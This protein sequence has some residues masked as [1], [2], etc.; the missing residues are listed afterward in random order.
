MTIQQMLLGAGGKTDPK[1]IDDYWSTSH[2]EGNGQSSRTINNGIDFSSGKGMVFIV[3]STGEH[4]PYIFSTE[5]KNDNGSSKG[6]KATFSSGYSNYN[7]YCTLTSTGMTV[8]NNNV[9]NQNGSR[10]LAHFFKAEKGFFDIVT[11]TGNETQRTISHGLGTN[12][13]QM[14]IKRT[15]GSHAW[16]VYHKDAVTGNGHWM[17]LSNSNALQNSGNNDWYLSGFTSSTFG[18]GNHSSING[19]NKEYIAF[20]WSDGSDASWGEDKDEA[21]I[22]C[23]TYTGNGSSNRDSPLTVNVGFEPSFCLYKAP[24]AGGD[25]MMQNTINRWGG[26]DDG[27]EDRFNRINKYSNTNQGAIGSRHY[28]WIYNSGIKVFSNLNQNNQKYVYMAIRRMG[29][30]PITTAAEAYASVTASSATRNNN[31]LG[32]FAVPTG[33][34]DRNRTV[35]LMFEKRH[36]SSNDWE[37]GSRLIHGRRMPTNKDD[38]WGT[39]TGFDFSSNF[40]FGTGY[41]QYH[42]GNMF[43]RAYGY[44]DIQAYNG[45]NTNQ[46]ITHELGVVP[47]MIWFKNNAGTNMLCAI[48]ML[49]NNYWGATL[50]IGARDGSD[51]LNKSRYDKQSHGWLSADPTAT[52]VYLRG[53][54]NANQFKWTNAPWNNGQQMYLWK[55][56]DGVMKIGTYNGNNSSWGNAINCGFSNGCAFILVKRYNGNGGGEVD[57]WIC[58]TEQGFNTNNSDMMRLNRENSMDGSSRIINNY[59][60]GFRVKGDLN[61][62]DSKWFYM[63]VAAP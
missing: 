5:A 41:N 11:Y 14:W 19:N 62:S 23:G 61:Y 55:Q 35:D 58:N 47:D 17:N 56:V 18:L 53:S 49:D 12:I 37:W 46:T 16:T 50:N 13:G 40:G 22:K 20:I 52:E 42:I 39:D 34:T 32:S 30:K 1:Y 7:S 21:I 6:L 51:N 38:A 43:P 26:Q 24:D 45:T 44:L 3:A 59:S 31:P 25:W 27:I 60:A 28:S 36:N 63:A 33:M 57:W 10:Y 54:T 8:N 9:V 15:D 4:D 2:Y 48:P 29:Q